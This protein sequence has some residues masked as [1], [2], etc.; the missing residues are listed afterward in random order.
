MRLLKRASRAADEKSDPVIEAW[1]SRYGHAPQ[2]DP[3]GL[4]RGRRLVA[5]RLAAAEADA[6][7]SGGLR[8]RLALA[9]LGGGGIWASM[10]GMAAAHPVLAAAAA[11]SVLAGGAT[12]A[13][14]TGVGPAV[15]QAV[16]SE[17]PATSTDATATATATSAATASLEA[18]SIPEQAAPGA[19]G[20]EP[21]PEGAPGNL[22][23]QLHD[24]G[25]FTMRA[26][27]VDATSD[28]ISLVGV[29]G[30]VELS[31]DEEAKLQIPG[32]PSDDEELDEYSG[33]LV[34]VSGACESGIELVGPGCVVTSVQ[35]LGHAGANPSE[36]A[37]GSERDERSKD[38]GEA[39]DSEEHGKPERA[40][41][42]RS[43]DPDTDADS[44]D[45]EDSDDDEG[46]DR[47]GDS[48]KSEKPKPSHP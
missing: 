27:L 21:V 22:V 10:S 29:G 14:V 42:P 39:G 31:L 6:A 30:I 2:V 4:E 24:D 35:V 34:F 9:G 38:R 17:A 37:P 5:S 19:L 12:A 18:T 1:F 11:L 45:D 23:T 15:R 44:E 7:P 41:D 32:K 25:R 47:H 28:S 8:R 13:E 26:V 33:Q 46:S 16:R 48:G 40:V 43:G 36:G 3:Q 20:I